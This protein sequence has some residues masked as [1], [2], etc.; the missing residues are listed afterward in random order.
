MKKALK[1][2]TD[3]ELVELD[4]DTED[5][6]RVMQEAVEGLIQPIDFANF[7]VWVNEEG[8][9]RNDLSENPFGL[10]LTGRPLIGNLLV[11]GGVDD[12]G[13]TLGIPEDVEH[14]ITIRLDAFKSLM[15]LVH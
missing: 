14:A 9:L 6:L 2:T 8:L 15:G 5:S 13:D 11:T 12:E 7:T 10:V 3:L 1:I 4:L